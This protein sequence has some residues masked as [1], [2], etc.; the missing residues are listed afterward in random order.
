MVIFS[1]AAF[2]ALAAERAASPLDTLW[3]KMKEILN[4]AIAASGGASLIDAFI[5]KLKG[6]GTTALAAE[7]AASVTVVARRCIAVCAFVLAF[8][9]P[10]SK[11]V[12]ISVPRVVAAL[13]TV[14]FSANM[15]SMGTDG[16]AAL[17]TSLTAGLATPIDTSGLLDAGAIN[18]SMTAAGT[19]GAAALTLGLNT[20]LSGAT[21]YNAAQRV[22]IYGKLRYAYASAVPVGYRVR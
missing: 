6:I 21:V 8:C 18:T 9:H 17:N 12:F 15:T 14:A 7:R 1:N 4:E 19:D 16:A 5:E 11:A 2:T 10:L 22:P 20:G 13:D 3:A